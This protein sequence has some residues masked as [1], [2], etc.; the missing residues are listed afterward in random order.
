[1]E[2]AER[3]GVKVITDGQLPENALL[4][5]ILETAIKVQV[6]NTLRHAHGHT[7]YASYS[8]EGD[9]YV[10]VFE[11]DGDAPKEEIREGGGIGNLRRM[12]EQ[13]G[14]SLVLSHEPR[15]SMRLEIPV[16]PE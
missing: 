9:K 4:K 8:M 10:I 5:D 7:V 12:V 2:D 14:G 13:T 16:E 15:F 6:N 3:L 1:M 11:N